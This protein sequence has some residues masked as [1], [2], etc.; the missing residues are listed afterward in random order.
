MKYSNRQKILI[1]DDEPLNISIVAEI[2]N[3]EYDLL[4]ATNG[5]KALQIVSLDPKPDL[6]LLDIM[7]PGMNGF[8]VAKRLKEIPETFQIPII[9]LTAKHDSE[10]IIKGFE[11]GAVDFVSKPFQKEELLARI[12]NTLQMF[13]LKNALNRALEKSQKYAKTVESQMVLIDKNI[14]IS[15]TDL[16]GKITE[17]SDAFCKISG[18]KKEQIIG[19]MHR[20]LR[21]PDM[22]ASLFVKLWETISRGD[23]W[24]GEIK[25]RSKNGSF[26]WVDTLIY[27]IVDDLGNHI[28]YTSISQNI[29]D[30]KRVEEIS[31]TDQLTQLHN[32]M[33]LESSF[34]KEIKRAKR[35]HHLFAVIM[36]DIDHFKEVNDT[37]GHDV[38]DN[39]LVSIS[40]IL[41]ENIRETDIL[42]RWGGEEFLIIC[43]H[44]SSLEAY[45]LAEKLRVS[46]ET[47][48]IDVIGY[49]SCSFGVS[50][51]DLNDET[52][53]EVL[54]H[55]DEAL[56]VA[57]KSGRNR[58]VEYKG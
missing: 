55:S 36:I 35:Y 4:V 38:G 23:T 52:F 15:H 1:V 11:A 32:R 54:K 49:K 16:A 50:V 53:K 33:Y 44:T 12:K 41:S 17:V 5:E 31:V 18:Y 2:L 30:K 26:Y 56:Y 10:S 25:N 28:G 8:E 51:F 13:N 47:H 57:K 45:N 43:P 21:H 3:H 6:I 34:A 22:P 14:I 42:G 24:Q 48:P 29:T 20:V 7:M 27:P 9:F 39:V 46:I 19:K 58:V 37:Y 40:Q